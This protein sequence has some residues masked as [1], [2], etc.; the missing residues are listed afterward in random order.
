[1]KTLVIFFG[2]LLNSVVALAQFESLSD[3]E[4]PKNK[5]DDYFVQADD[6]V[7]CYAVAFRVHK[8]IVN[9][10]TGDVRERDCSGSTVISRKQKLEYYCYEYDQVFKPPTAMRAESLRV[11]MTERRRAYSTETGYTPKSS[12]VEPNPE[13]GL[14]SNEPSKDFF[15]DLANEIDPYGL[16]LAA[17]RAS[18]GR[19]SNLDKVLKVWITNLELKSEREEKGLLLTKWNGF[20]RDENSVGLRE[21]IFDSHV[22]SLPVTSRVHLVDSNGKKVVSEVRTIWDEYKAGKWRPEKCILSY[23]FG[24]DRF[25]EE[26]EYEWAEPEE[27][28]AFL[29]THDWKTIITEEQREWFKIFSDFLASRKKRRTDGTP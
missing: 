8:V 18:R 16:V 14:R 23:T 12:I 13:T 29:V 10:E 21:L 9:E 28:D 17:T 25:Q 19:N 5:L 26:F 2:V 20:G 11:G 22:G 6:F 7:N 4:S 1:M 15:S 3:K 24:R 27:L